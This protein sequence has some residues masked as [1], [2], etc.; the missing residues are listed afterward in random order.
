MN[1]VV[2][3]KGNK[4]GNLSPFLVIF[5]AKLLSRVKIEFRAVHCAKNLF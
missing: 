2:G 5:T 3:V 1:E 4:K